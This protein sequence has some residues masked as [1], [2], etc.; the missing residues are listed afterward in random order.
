ME[1]FGFEQASVDDLF[2]K[3]RKCSLDGREQLSGEIRV[4]QEYVMKHIKDHHEAIKLAI[5][6]V[7]YLSEDIGARGSQES[8]RNEIAHVLAGI[9]RLYRQEIDGDQPS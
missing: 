3:Y 4:L 1:L 2:E 5:A 6:G 8:L 7:E 9:R